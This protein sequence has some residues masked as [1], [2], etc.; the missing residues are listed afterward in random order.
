MLPI[1]TVIIFS[2]AGLILLSIVVL[3]ST[4]SIVSLIVVL[5]VIVML[6]YLL[7]KLGVLDINFT[8]STL[9][10][11]FHEVGGEPTPNSTYEPKELVINKSEVFHISGNKYTYEDAPAVCA[12]YNSSLA[13]YDQV[14][15]SYLSGAEW[16]GYGWSQGGMA[17]FPTQTAT[18]EALQTE[19]DISKRTRCGRA[20]VNG[21]YFD[22]ANKFGVNCY[23]IKPGN[24]KQVKFPQPLPNISPGFDAAVAKFRRMLNSIDISGFNRQ[25]WSEWAN[26]NIQLYNQ[27]KLKV[28]SKPLSEKKNVATPKKDDVPIEKEQDKNIFYDWLTSTEKSMETGYNKLV[29]SISSNLDPNDW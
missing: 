2:I 13:T 27:N 15:E 16:C 17:L 8:D 19:L 10:I 12:A 18:W 3:I 23:G 28:D 29:N 14:N 9:D 1:P 6:G 5:T 26:S 20:G 25:T 11:K 4:G 22:P 24:Q 21:G 7:I